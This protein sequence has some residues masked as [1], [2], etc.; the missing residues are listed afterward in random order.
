MGFR[1]FGPVSDHFDGVP[2]G[3]RV[4]GFFGRDLD[5]DLS[6]FKKRGFSE[7]VILGGIGVSQ[8]WG[9]DSR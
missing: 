7:K 9:P 8:F 2:P 3:K 6:T 4:F 1:V 5:E